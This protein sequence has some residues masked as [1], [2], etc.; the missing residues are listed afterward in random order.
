MAQ[1]ASIVASEGPPV[2]IFTVP[3]PSLTGEARERL[4]ASTEAS[5]V[6]PD[7]APLIIVLGGISGT[8]TVVRHSDGAPGWWP[9]VFGP[10]SA[11][12]TDHYRIL[13]IDFVADDSGAYAP[14]TL[15]QAAIIR[16]TLAALGEAEAFAIVGA[17]YG[18]MVALA[19]AAEARPVATRLVIIGAAH[20][21]HPMATAARSL[22]RQVVAL[23]V[24]AGRASEGLALARAMAM[25][26]YRTPREFGERFVGGIT[27]SAPLAPSEP[28]AYLDARGAAFADVMSAGRFLSLSASIDRHSVDPA[29]VTVPTLVVATEEDQIVP[30]VQAAQFAAALGGQA[31]FRVIRSIY[32]HD[33]FLKEPAMIETL[34][35]EHLG[36]GA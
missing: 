2:T 24:S 36:T 13:G 17:S 26:T 20:C 9:A 19:Y 15:D 32:G 35:H 4:P 12:G 1:P 29:A 28:R 8:K 33:S 11:V 18:G 3:L 31:S 5:I 30:L 6:G 10:G 27:T 7:G 34:V 14:S 16:D 25:T 22:Q 23:G 21:P